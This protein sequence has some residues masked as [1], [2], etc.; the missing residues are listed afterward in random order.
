M[1]GGGQQ[2][3]A[4][5]GPGRKKDRRSGNARIAHLGLPAGAGKNLMQQIGRH[6][7]FGSQV[8]HPGL[9]LLGLFEHLPAGRTLVLVTA[10]G[11]RVGRAQSSIQGIGEKGLPLV[12]P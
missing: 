2:H 7:G 5:R 3:A 4:P 9:A 10:E 8:L 1:A 12:V 11:G 6:F